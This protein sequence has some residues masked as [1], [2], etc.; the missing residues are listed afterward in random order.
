MNDHFDKAIKSL[1]N[2]NILL[3]DKHGWLLGFCTLEVMCRFENGNHDWFEYRSESLKKMLKR[4]VKNDSAGKDKRIILIFKI[5]K[6]LNKLNYDF[7]AT[8]KLEAESMAQLKDG[9]G[10]YYWN[11]AGS[12]LLR[13]DEWME[14]KVQ[15]ASKRGSNSTAIKAA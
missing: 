11:P 12:E 5:M 2:C 9:K 14:S 13:F 1:K 6:T 7:A 3:K 8:V 10:Q 4:H 15:S